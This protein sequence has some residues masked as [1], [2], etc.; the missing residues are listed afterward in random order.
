MVRVPYLAVGG[1]KDGPVHDAP[2]MMANP[3]R[4]TSWLT[5]VATLATVRAIEFT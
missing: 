3:R 2:M 4:A 5:V 1:A